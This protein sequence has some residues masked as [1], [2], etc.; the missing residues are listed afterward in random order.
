MYS[1]NGI[2]TTIYGKSAV[3]PQDGS[4]VATKWVVFLWLPIIPIGTY[5]VRREEISPNI[6]PV[7]YT[8]TYTTQ[9][10]DLNWRQVVSTYLLVWGSIACLFVALVYLFG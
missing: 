10:I 3:S 6:F 4:Y 9:R 5:R 8:A 1:L 7:G 2:G